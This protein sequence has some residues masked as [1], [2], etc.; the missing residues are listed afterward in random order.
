MATNTLS[1]S[2]LLANTIGVGLPNVEPLVINKRDQ[3]SSTLV[4]GKLPAKARRDRVVGNTQVKHK[5]RLNDEPTGE[6]GHTFRKEITSE[7]PKKGGNGRNELKRNQ[8]PVAVGQPSVILPLIAQWSLK[9]GHGPDVIIKK[10]E[11]KSG[12][13]HAQ[14][15][16]NL[17]IDKSLLGIGK[18]THPQ[19]TEPIPIVNSKQT[20]LKEIP[21]KTSQIPLSAGI[22]PNKDESADGMQTLE[23]RP[24]A[25]KGVVN[26]QN[27]EGFVH[28]P[29][30]RSHHGITTTNGKPEDVL[31]SKTLD[32]RQTPTLSGEELK[33]QA[34][35]ANSGITSV[36][37][38]AAIVSPFSAS[39]S[40]KTLPFIIEEFTPQ[41]FVDTHSR[42][43]SIS[44][45]DVTFS[46]STASGSQKAPP[47]IVEELAPKALIGVDSEVT[48]VIQ[49]PAIAVKSVVSNSQ[50]VYEQNSDLSLVKGKPSELQPQSVGVVLRKSQ[51]TA[52]Q[53]VDNKTNPAQRDQ[54][55]PESSTDDKATAVRPGRPGTPQ[56]S[57]PLPDVLTEKGPD[58]SSNLDY[59]HLHRVQLQ[60]SNG[61]IKG[62][63]G[64]VSGNNNAVLGFGQIL[65]GSNAATYIE[66][67]ISIFPEAVK[68]GNLPVKDLPNNVSA[69]ITK[70]ILESI[71]SS[72]SQKAEIQQITIRF[73]PPEL[74]KVFIKFEEQENQ[75]T[76]LV[77]VSK[78]ET[79]YEVEQ[80]LPQIVQN[81][82]ACGIQIKR[83]EVV[84]TDQNE[85]HSYGDESL[86]D[87]LFQQHHDLLKGNNPDT[88][89]TLGDNDISI[90]RNNSSYKDGFEPHVQITD[91]S[92]NILI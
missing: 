10:I 90:V 87:G 65:S 57:E 27:S 56:L 71:Q 37:G 46:T 84:L 17:S 29:L 49:K 4:E 83:L 54:I 77:E 9:D 91:T 80:A 75:L 79:R 38:K 5:N 47:F 14:S 61:T 85:Q 40:Q 51:L 59:Q 32:S 73:H 34:V 82:A 63:D 88:H 19:N 12:L 67:P 30:V 7:I 86:Q 44:E 26:R 39:G 20:V 13:E 6:F 74:G 22:Q 11:L 58:S 33:H 43:T 15:Y 92:I 23:G 62:R 66:E 64:S 89:E 76:G 55:L 45:K 2:N 1:I 60:V 50:K 81:L 69:S 48:H 35:V 28:Q 25:A 68:T 24:F 8:I 3:S 41:T 70:Q 72:S 18:T 16:N 42:I 21:S 31:I 52:E 53:G 78:A 36:G